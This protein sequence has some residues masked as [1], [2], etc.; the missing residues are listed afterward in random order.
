MIL[1]II[2]NG[3][4]TLSMITF[5]KMILRIMTLSITTLGLI[6]LSI[7]TFNIIILCILTISP[8]TLSMMSICVITHRIMTHSLTAICLITVITITKMLC[9]NMHIVYKIQNATFSVILSV[10]MLGDIMINVVQPSVVAPFSIT[11]LF[12]FLANNPYIWKMQLNK[13]AKIYGMGQM[14]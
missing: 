9:W 5:N 4:T 14:L 7:A 3:T 1:S 13:L 8:T 11:A 6:T 12:F 2:V 10:V